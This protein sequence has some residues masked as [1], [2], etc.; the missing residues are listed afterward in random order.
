PYPDIVGERDLLSVVHEIHRAITCGVPALDLLQDIASRA[1]TFTGATTIAIALRDE[2]ESILRFVAAAGDRSR[3]LL[4]LHIDAEASLADASLR[5]G[6]PF[7][8]GVPDFSPPQETGPA[9]SVVVPIL[10]QN[11]SIGAVFALSDSQSDSLSA[12]ASDT[13]ELFAGLVAVAMTADTQG[14]VQQRKSRELAALYESARTVSS[15]LNN[16]D[17]LESV[18]DAVCHASTHETAVIFLL[19]DERSHLFVAAQRGLTDEEME[20]QL[21]VDDVLVHRM[22]E[23]GQATILRNTGDFEE[24][25]DLLASDRIRTVMASPIRSRTENIGIVVIV[26]PLPDAFTDGDLNL[27]TAVASQ[28]GIAVS[29][30]WLYEDT[31]RRAE[32][33]GKIFEMSQRLNATLDLESVCS[34]VTESVQELLRADRT[35]L[36]LL[37]DHGER[38]RVISVRG[39][40]AANFAK[41]RPKIGEGIPGWVC[42]WM[43]P[44]AIADVAADARNFS[45]PIHL[46][47]V[48]ST[49]CVPIAVGDDVI[50]VLMAISSRRRLFTVGEMEL[51]FT[52]ANQA[53]NAI[54]N[55]RNFQAARRRTARLR[56]YFMRLALALG[57]SLPREQAP[58]LLTELALEVMRADRC[59]LYRLDEE[60]LTLVASAGF[61]SSIRPDATI[62][63][64]VGFTGWVAK[65]SKRLVVDVVQDDPRREDH[66]WVMKERPSSYLGIPLRHRGKVVGV[67][68]IYSMEPRKFEIEEVELLLQFARRSQ[69]AERIAG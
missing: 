62:A 33:T 7:Y 65:R 13:L 46:E 18:L 68:E 1:L 54:Q 49:L 26:S 24:I 42:E 12:D 20:I 58:Q 45:Y 3:E 61:R 51:L 27:L 47:G 41:I 11:L 21:S 67:M 44:T 9:T 32:E 40:D 17:V 66:A 55:S 28:A 48:V 37:D 10:Q 35:A 31:T 30:S 29:N 63:N 8:F 19:N 60:E 50:G 16:Q 34:Y 43:T 2:D 39:A 25:K 14:R 56:R 59:K 15:T 69:T 53:G 6:L 4:G 64:G 52:V 5:T 38:L 22:F 57:S 23:T 36:L